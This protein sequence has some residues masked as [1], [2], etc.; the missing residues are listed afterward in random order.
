MLEIPIKN[1]R[2]AL[3]KKILY[4]MSIFIS[5]INCGTVDGQRHAK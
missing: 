1:V 2:Y 4:I 3:F 5:W